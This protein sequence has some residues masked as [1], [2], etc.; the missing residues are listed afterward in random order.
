VKALG[1]L[2]RRLLLLG[3]LAFLLLNP[4][5]LAWL[6]NW[7][8][9]SD[10]F[11][12]ADIVVVLQGPEAQYIDRLLAGAELIRQGRAGHMVI[13]GGRWGQNMRRLIDEGFEPQA[14]WDARWLEVLA[15][16]DVPDDS[17]QVIDL[18]D[19]F[20]TVSEAQGNLAVI[21]GQEVRHIAVVTSS[22]H[23]RR[24]GTVWRTQ[25]GERYRISVVAAGG[26]AFDVDGWWKDLSQIRLV[27]TEFGGWLFSMIS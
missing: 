12:Q 24:A 4:V 8:V 10:E 21:G 2:V 13:N 25:A 17:I 9:V 6:G 23:T 3:T 5:T 27:V 15:H 16:V 22:Y 18:R 1:R 14:R 20:D 11:D 19:V 7:L 26:E